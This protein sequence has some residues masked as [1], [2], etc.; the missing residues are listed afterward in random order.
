VTLAGETQRAL[1]PSLPAKLT[2]AV[3]IPPQPV[4]QFAIAVATVGGR[5]E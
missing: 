2:F 5:P 3:E 4:L 1:T